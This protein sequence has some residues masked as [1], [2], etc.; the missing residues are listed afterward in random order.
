MSDEKKPPDNVKH[1]KVVKAGPPPPPTP[2]G[3]FDDSKVISA[4]ENAIGEAKAGGWTE[5]VITMS[6]PMTGYVSLFG[7]NNGKENGDGAGSM[8]N[9]IGAHTMT[10][11]FLLEAACGED[12]QA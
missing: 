8:Y 11:K 3:D 6:K 5:V 12:E 4:L 10:H 7:I 2:P 1:L 9:L